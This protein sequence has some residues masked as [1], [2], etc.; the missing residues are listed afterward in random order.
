MKNIY[1]KPK[2]TEPQFIEA[3]KQGWVDVR[4]GEVLVA[5]PNLKK[6]IED[7][8][9]EKEDCSSVII[10]PEIQTEQIISTAELE[11]DLTKPD[12][13]EDDIEEKL[14]DIIEEDK[15]IAPKKRRGRPA[16][17]D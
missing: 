16:K 13:T 17:Q 15:L 10:Q 3:T 14:K 4:T 7:F 12:S 2:T 11:V 6:R 5:V 9:G 1:Q 8:F